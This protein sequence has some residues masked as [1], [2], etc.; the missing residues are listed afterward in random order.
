M[1][2]Y[3]KPS[4][5]LLAVGTNS[6][7]IGSCF[8]SADL[9]TLEGILGIPIDPATAFG[10]GEACQNQL[11][12]EGYCKFTSAQTGSTQVFVS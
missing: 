2:M 11:P 1:N 8:S 3:T 10:M 4:I 12:I 7:S 5:K 9:E 6:S